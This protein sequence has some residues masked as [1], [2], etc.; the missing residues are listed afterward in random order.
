MPVASAVV[1]DAWAL[2]AY[3]RGEQPAGET[4][5]RYLRRAAAGRL[6]IL[7]G[8]VNLGEVYYRI[9]QIG[10]ERRADQAL[11]IVRGLPLETVPAK[12]DLALEAARLKGRYSLPYADAFAVALGRLESAPVATGDP[13]IIGLPRGVVRVRRLSRA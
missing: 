2:L 13:D 11:A 8:V 4:V 10:G 1:A 9:W 5:R 12:E 3:L 6:R 7:L